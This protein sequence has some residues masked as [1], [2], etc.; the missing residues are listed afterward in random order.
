MAGVPYCEA[1]RTGSAA[2]CAADVPRGNGSSGVTA[3]AP[4]EYDVG[5]HLRRRVLGAAVP[6]GPKI[7]PFEQ[8]LAGAQQNRRDG[9]VHLIDEI[10]A[11]VL[12]NGV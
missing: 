6:K 10:C 4:R 5:C 11:Q 7:D 1:Q 9:K 2:I 12:L 8:S 3:H